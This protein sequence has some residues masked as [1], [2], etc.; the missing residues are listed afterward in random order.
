MFLSWG[1]RQG[2]SVR[3]DWTG[4]LNREMRSQQLDAAGRV[5]A[6]EKERLGAK[7]ITDNLKFANIENAYDKAQLVDYTQKVSLPAVGKI[8]AENPNWQYDVN[9]RMQV[10]NTINGVSDNALS[11]LGKS[12]D[13]QYKALNKY[14]NENKESGDIDRQF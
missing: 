7:D 11:A 5:A 13:E 3:N 2:L 4:D 1:M 10:M 14:L 6:K 12:N 9:Q 8:V